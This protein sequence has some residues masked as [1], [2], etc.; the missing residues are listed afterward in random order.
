MDTSAQDMHAGAAVD[1]TAHATEH[2][3]QCSCVHTLLYMQQCCGVVWWLRPLCLIVYCYADLHDHNGCTGFQGTGHVGVIYLN[4]TNSL[5][6]TLPKLC[7]CQQ[8]CLVCILCR[9]GFILGESDM[10]GRTAGAATARRQRSA[11]Q[12]SRTAGTAVRGC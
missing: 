3:T 12:V 7:F 9:Y 10:A 5:Q 2:G 6:H 4:V 1:S 8:R 11:S